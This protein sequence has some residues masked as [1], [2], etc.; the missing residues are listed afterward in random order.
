MNNYDKFDFLFA[1]TTTTGSMGHSGRDMHQCIK[2]PLNVDSASSDLEFRPTQRLSQS[3]NY[4]NASSGQSYLNDSDKD[5]SGPHSGSRHSSGTGK[6]KRKSKE[7][8][9]SDF[10]KASGKILLGMEKM[11]T[12]IMSSA[13]QLGRIDGDRNKK[14]FEELKALDLRRP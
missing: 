5:T 8:E 3:E 1:T 14:V 4:T 9:Q 11:C 12:A 10:E 6:S 13:K 7:A 2:R